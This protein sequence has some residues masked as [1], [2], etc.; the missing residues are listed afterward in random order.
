MRA[1]LRGLALLAFV[2]AAPPR[3]AAA[4]LLADIQQVRDEAR[5]VQARAEACARMKCPIVDCAAL[6]K[7]TQD[8]VD[9]EAALD[10]LHGA[11][12]DANADARKHYFDLA[13]NSH[14]TGV[15]LAQLQES[16]AWQEFFHKLGSYLL[17]M[18][19]ILNTLNKNIGSMDV[20]GVQPTDGSA[21]EALESLDNLAN[22]AKNL[23][24][25]GS[26]LTQQLA[27][28]EV[29]ST[30][31]AKQ[32]ANTS[33]D[34]KSEGVD[35]AKLARDARSAY[36]D[37][38][39]AA[40]FSK[41]KGSRNL[42]TLLGRTLKMY[43]E[44]KIKEEKAVLKD[45]KIDESAEATALSHAYQEWQRVREQLAA[46]EDALAALRAAR[47]ALA[48]C[49][50]RAKCGSMTL[51][52]PV[53][54]PFPH[55]G[56]AIK[57]LAGKLPGLAAA[58]KGSVAVKDKCPEPEKTPPPPAEKPAATP[59]T[60]LPPPKHV[61]E[62]NCPKCA[63]IALELARTL[64]ERDFVVGEITR[65]RQNVARAEE[66]EKDAKLLRDAIQRITQLIIDFR[67][68]KKGKNALIS[69]GNKIFDKLGKPHTE[70]TIESLERE[71]RD[72]QNQLQT[73]EEKMKALRAEEGK[74][75]A[76]QKENDRLFDLGEKLRADLAECQKSCAPPPPPRMKQCYNEKAV[77]DTADIRQS[78][79][80]TSTNKTARDAALKKLCECL[81]QHPEEMT[82]E[83]RKLCPDKSIGMA[84]RKTANC[85][86]GFVYSADA[87]P[88]EK[89]CG[90]LV[91]NPK[92]YEDSPRFRVVEIPARLPV[93]GA[94]KPVL[95]ETT[96]SFGDGPPQPGDGPVTCKVPPGGTTN[97]SIGTVDQ[98]SVAKVPVT[99]PGSPSN[100]PGPPEVRTPPTCAKGDFLTL[101]GRF[102]GDPQSVRVDVGGRRAPIST[103]TPR[104]WN[105]P[106]PDDV[107]V[108]P[109]T[110]IYEE[111]GRQS[112]G[113]IAVVGLLMSADRTDLLRGESTSFA[114]KVVGLGGVPEEAWNAPYA[115]ER[116]GRSLLEKC[117]PGMELPAGRPGRLVL[118]L[119][120][121]S[122]DVISIDGE[123]DGR[124][125]LVIDRSKV[126]DGAFEF[127]GKIRSLQRGTFNI[128]GTLIAL[129]AP[130][131]FVPL[132]RE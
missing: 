96:V 6:A 63:G 102:S 131:R 28:G 116:I 73:L 5:A 13:A 130:V 35:V 119:E 60:P 79:Y 85:L 55:Y 76:L 109:A 10:A 68:G 33:W 62:N 24:D 32:L 120:N 111:G 127:K 34:V 12:I 123:K 107:P 74:L 115:P 43:S 31:E 54:G 99:C 46:A 42:L 98:T 7:T 17:K 92:D 112:A 129:M 37:G 114:A 87:R 22:L 89:I 97:I 122:R 21:L 126:K 30:P 50:A 11:L 57:A 52:R 49:R 82:D 105:C 65:I 8:L 3:R 70:I 27:T 26:D 23:G 44:R 90:T 78:K 59:A 56:D 20:K 103:G 45:L 41:L 14:L 67:Q 106:L 16:L 18:E 88:N 19:S 94:G 100:A 1:R 39:A 81:K 51:S 71:K 128:R 61:V 4:D 101:E 75:D 40:A 69:I 104:E 48:A 86:V 53:F 124:I 15:M 95:A 25:I 64:D 77:F 83:L 121:A 118:V 91:D 117:A 93:D 9:A 108:G 125:V 132:A 29:G 38:G 110:V 113:K 72:R 2:L 47:D 66:M 80:P 84:P 58:L 36:N